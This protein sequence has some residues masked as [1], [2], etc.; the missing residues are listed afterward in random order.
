M[1]VNKQCDKNCAKKLIKFNDLSVEYVEFESKSGFSIQFCDINSLK[2]SSE[3][4][5]SHPYYTLKSRIAESGHFGTRAI[6]ERKQTNMALNRILIK[7]FAMLLGA[8]C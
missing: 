6:S 8:D 1:H 5:R 3:V 7:I 2:V 4:F